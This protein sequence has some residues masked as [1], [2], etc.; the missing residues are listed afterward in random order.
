VKVFSP[1][2]PFDSHSSTM[3]QSSSLSV[4]TR[5]KIIIIQYSTQ[6][7]TSSS[8]RNRKEWAERVANPFLIAEATTRIS[9][10]RFR[11][12]WLYSRQR[13]CHSEKKDNRIHKSVSDV[14]EAR[15]GEV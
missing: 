3:R 5:T 1:S 10:S 12:E 2:V 8:G 4:L 13:C 11:D 7:H 6:L 15:E 14:T 9:N